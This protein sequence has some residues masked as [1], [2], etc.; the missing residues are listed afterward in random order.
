M[1][2]DFQALAENPGSGYALSRSKLWAL[3]ALGELYSSRAIPRGKR[4]PGLDYFAKATR[5]LRVVCER[6][7]LDAI[8]LRLLLVSKL[9]ALVHGLSSLTRNSPRGHLLSLY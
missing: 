5:V 8:E 3:F 6:P 7:S 4:Y 9:R 1:W 2:E